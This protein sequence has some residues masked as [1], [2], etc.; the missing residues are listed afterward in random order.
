MAEKD[1][2]DR[3]LDELREL[4]TLVTHPETGV[5]IRLDRIQQSH[6]KDLPVT[7]EKQHQRIKNL[8]SAEASRKKLV[9]AALMS[10]VG[11]AGAS[12]WAWIS[13]GGK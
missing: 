12:A 9:M 3:V 5:I 2:L 13:Q 6:I 1:R 4:N 11:A 7:L 10:A 8:E